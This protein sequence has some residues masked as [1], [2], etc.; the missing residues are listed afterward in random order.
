MNY[1][2]ND[3]QDLENK[4]HLIQLLNN[5]N[6]P[7]VEPII[8][9]PQNINPQNNNIP[10][11]QPILNQIYNQPIINPDNNNNIN[12]NNNKINE[13]EQENNKLKNDIIQLDN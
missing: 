4:L 8:N 6:I 9:N 3:P 10:E 5:N 12:N 13:L 2:I 1:P 11:N 7:F